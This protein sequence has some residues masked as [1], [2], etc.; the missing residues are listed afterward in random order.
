MHKEQACFCMNYGI[1]LCEKPM[2][3]ILGYSS[4]KDTRDKTGKFLAM[5][6]TGPS[7]LLF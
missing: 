2:T 6:L 1:V 4:L 7:S 3:A 5:G